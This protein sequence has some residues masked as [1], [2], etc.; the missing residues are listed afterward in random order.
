MANYPR[1]DYCIAAYYLS[2]LTGIPLVTYMHDL[3]SEN[4]SDPFEKKLATRYEPKLMHHS[5]IIYAI[6]DKAKD[7]Y[8]NKYKIENIVVLPH[9]IDPNFGVDYPE[10]INNEI[11]KEFLASSKYIKLVFVG[12]IYKMNSDALHFIT[13]AIHGSKFKLLLCTTTPKKSL[14]KLGMLNNN[15]VS[16][17]TNRS[18]AWSIQKQSDIILIPLSFNSIKHEI[19]TVFPTKVLEHLL[20]K[21]PM[22]SVSPNYSFLHEDI[23][24]HDYSATLTELKAD[25]LLNVLDILTKDKYLKKTLVDNALKYAEM[26]KATNIINI[27]T[28]SM[29]QLI[30]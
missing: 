4:I 14:I 15:V 28:D 19:E 20:A 10:E 24:K 16:T 22:L 1:P 26:R 12:A 3:W 5:E 2:K 17:M 18:D 29:N 23:A 30:R 8:H 6:T 7:F 11:A 21:T 9:S 27:F 13:K 25:Q